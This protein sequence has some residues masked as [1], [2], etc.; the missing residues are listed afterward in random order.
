MA[1]GHG[2]TGH[3]PSTGPMYRFGSEAAAGGAAATCPPAR[4]QVCPAVAQVRQLS[5]AALSPSAA[6]A[7]RRPWAQGRAAGAAW[8]PHGNPNPA[9]ETGG[10]CGPRRTLK[11]RKEPGCRRRGPLGSSLSTQP[12]RSPPAQW[13]SDRLLRISPGG[14]P[15]GIDPSLPGRAQGLH[16]GGHQARRS[17]HGGWGIPQKCPVPEG[18]LYLAVWAP[19]VQDAVRPPQVLTASPQPARPPGSSPTDSSTSHLA[20]GPQGLC[21]GCWSACTF[22]Q[23]TWPLTTGPQSHVGPGTPALSLSGGAR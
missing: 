21:S 8:R 4:G 6:L 19:P 13:G 16:V 1:P 15:W 17:S 5:A 23:T 14:T 20:P 11:V 18:C 3:G 10:E 22:P 2:V 12:G 9:G 7:T